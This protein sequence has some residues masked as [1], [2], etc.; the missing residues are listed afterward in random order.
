ML[1]TLKDGKVVW[2]KYSSSSFNSDIKVYKDTFLT[3]DF[4]NVIRAISSEDG[5]ELWNFKTEN[6][7]IKSQKKFDNFK[8]EIVFLLII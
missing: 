7:F 1:Q 5:T 4:D 8:D 3:I 2:T 6:S